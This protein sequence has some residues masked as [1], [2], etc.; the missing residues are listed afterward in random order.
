MSEFGEKEENIEKMK[1]SNEEL[2]QEL[3][4]AEKKAAIRAAKKSYGRDWK[5]V[6][7]IFKHIK[8]DRETMMDLHSMGIGGEEL[9]NLNRPPSIRRYR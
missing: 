1:L 8:V 9:R 7:G 4:L 3:S 6:L 5:K 2:D